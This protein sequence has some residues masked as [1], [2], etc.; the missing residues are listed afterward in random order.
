M[1]TNK[2]LNFGKPYFASVQQFISAKQL[3]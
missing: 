2:S 1:T 3:C